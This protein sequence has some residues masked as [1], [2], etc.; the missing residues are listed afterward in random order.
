[1][2]AKKSVLV[3]LAGFVVV[4]GVAAI[5]LG[6]P[7]REK[8]QEKRIRTLLLQV[9]EAVQNY[10]VDEEL[11]PKR[12]MP[13]GEL[14]AF[15]KEKGFLAEPLANPWTK[16][17]YESGMKEDWLEY[18]TDALAETYELIIY[19]PGTETVQFRLDS[20]KNQSLE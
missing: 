14:I 11:Y 20:T 18:R 19:Q 17:P 16:T 4:A 15:L 1:M 10:H 13:G 7:L 3:R 9:Q 5:L 2:T 8:R 6:V 12:R